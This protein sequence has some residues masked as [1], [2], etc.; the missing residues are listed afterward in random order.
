[1]NE[2][3]LDTIEKIR[4]FLHATTEATFSNPGDES[5]RR[6]VVTTVLNASEKALIARPPY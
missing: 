4:E 2:S 3:S 5:T 1:M 6:S